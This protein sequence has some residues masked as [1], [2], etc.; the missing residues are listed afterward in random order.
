MEKGLKQFIKEKCTVADH[1]DGVGVKM[2]LIS[3]CAK[4][5]D[6][7]G[8]TSCI[9]MIAMTTFVFVVIAKQPDVSR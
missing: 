1:G 3:G 9:G 2:K 8:F 5:I 6:F 4:R 7:L